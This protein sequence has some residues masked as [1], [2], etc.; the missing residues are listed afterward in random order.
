VASLGYLQKKVD[1]WDLSDAS[2]IESHLAEIQKLKEIVLEERRIRMKQDE[3]VVDTIL[4]A[5]G[6]LQE[7]IFDVVR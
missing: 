6:L 7:G 1:A 2:R 4:N 3:L 5:K